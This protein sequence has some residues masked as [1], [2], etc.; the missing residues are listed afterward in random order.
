MFLSLFTSTN[1]KLV[2]WG[3]VVWNYGIPENERDCYFGVP[4]ESQTTGPRTTNLPLVDHRSQLFLCV[5]VLFLFN[6]AYGLQQNYL[7]YRPQNDTTLDASLRL[8]SFY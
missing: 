3:L 1:G 4:L 6:L 7:N 5:T 2:V 8:N